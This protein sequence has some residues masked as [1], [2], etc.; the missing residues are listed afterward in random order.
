[1]ISVEN[2]NAVLLEQMP[3]VRS[4]ATKFMDRYDFKFGSADFDDILGWAIEGAIMAIE[5]HSNSGG[6][7]ISTFI[8]YRANGAIIDALRGCQIFK[9]P[10]RNDDRERLI[11]REWW[12][13]GLDES[14]ERVC[15]RSD[16]CSDVG[17]LIDAME[18]SYAHIIRWHYF[19]G[20]SMQHCAMR[21]HVSDAAGRELHDGAV[22]FLGVALK[23]MGHDHTI[24]GVFG[25][26]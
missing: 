14:P 26:G 2:R 18:N 13:I 3:V 5:R 16:V 24:I 17:N 10:N 15:M 19:D 20:L 11:P 21:A 12:V 25:N 7:S 6:A 8:R 4:V 1:M 23:A 9:H 22:L